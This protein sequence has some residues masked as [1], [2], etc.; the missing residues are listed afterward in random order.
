MPIPGSDDLWHQYRPPL[1]P[2]IPSGSHLSSQQT[3]IAEAE[4]PTHCP[5]RVQTLHL[6]RENT[7]CVPVVS[8]LQSV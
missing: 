1:L 4:S 8:V 5:L 2:T 3:P 6:E 7:K